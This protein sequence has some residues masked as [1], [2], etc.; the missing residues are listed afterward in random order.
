MKKILL[1]SNS[2]RRKELLHAMGFDFSVVKIDCD[3]SF[4]DDLPIPEVAAYISNLKSKA[5]TDILENKILITSDTV[6]SIDN[7][8][9][10]KPSDRNHAKEMLQQLSGKT[11]QVYTAFT[12]RTKN[13]ILSKT[14]VAHV[15]FLEI[16]EEEINYYLDSY[17][18]YDKAGSYG[19]QEWLGMTKISK[20]EGS[21]YTI[22]GL[23]SHLIYP[24]LKEL[25]S[26]ND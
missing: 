12:L 1:A 16:N 23:P 24:Y 17:Q 13:S 4:P 7:K 2:P 20:I 18:P 11:H 5:Y 22:M 9:L 3:E 14:D 10:G 21:F 25:I 15:S 19:I 6:V 8:I 26:H